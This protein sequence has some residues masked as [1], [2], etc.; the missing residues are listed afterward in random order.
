VVRRGLLLFAALVGLGLLQLAGGREVA[1]PEP[2]EGSDPGS[3]SVEIPEIHPLLTKPPSWAP[4][5]R[6]RPLAR[7]RRR[8][9]VASHAPAP[10]S[11][12]EQEPA[13]DGFEPAPVST[14]GAAPGPRVTPP[15]PP[16]FI[17]SPAFALELV[18]APPVSRPADE[19]EVAVSRSAPPSSQSTQSS[20]ESDHGH[21]PE[22]VSP[23]PAP[24]VSALPSLER[25]VAE[26]LPAG[27]VA[28]ERP[29]S[30]HTVTEKLPD[31]EVVSV[32]PSPERV[33]A[34]KLPAREVVSARL[35][36]ERAGIEKLPVR[37]VLPSR[38]RAAEEKLPVREVVSGPARVAP[39]AKPSAEVPESPSS[40]LAVGRQVDLEDLDRVAFSQ[41]I[42]VQAS[43]VLGGS[44]MIPGRLL[45]RGT[46]SPG[47]S[48]GL[49]EIAGDFS[50]SADARL[51]IELAG[52][53]PED[54]DRI[55][56]EGI[57]TLS[58]VIEVL[59]I[60]G[61]FP[62]AGD[63][64]AVLTA[65]RIVDEGVRFVLPALGAGSALA[66]RILDL[67]GTQVL[68]LSTTSAPQ[69]AAVPEAST[70]LLLALGLGGLAALR[71]LRV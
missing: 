21:P 63:S 71:R 41:S 4:R 37:E 31:R 64:F 3:V 35:S 58:G 15:P 50:Q 42:L 26:K 33:V 2:P 30:E 14:A 36:L 6:R 59:L 49:L 60:D 67:G 47:H 38:E 34:E 16:V 54:F 18:T 52:T 22:A 1:L 56:V 44:G 57:A 65:E 28:S 25:T 43:G 48:P 24:A 5:S 8:S 70:A 45:N 29:S 11:M 66:A 23:H 55:I 27:E 40:V 7:Q 53:S 10:I 69:L 19:L 9:L 46:V 68:E 62:E 20:L 39:E 32:R 13:G 61:F 12:P 17:P 51:D